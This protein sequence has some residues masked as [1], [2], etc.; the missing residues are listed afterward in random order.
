MC[1][2]RDIN[3]SRACSCGL[4]EVTFVCTPRCQLFKSVFARTE[5][6]QLSSM[7][8]L[9]LACAPR[10]QL[11][12]SMLMCTPRCQ[13]LQSAFV[14]AHQDVNRVCLHVLQQVRSNKSIS[15]EPI[16]M[17]SKMSTSYTCAECEAREAHAL[18]DTLPDN[19]LVPLYAETL[20]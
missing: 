20:I 1:T 4:Q 19:N 2:Q 8:L 7:C 14:C 17:H 15:Q 5:R 16:H 12:K 11:V 3:F 6:C 9:V 18:T 13:L 10:Y